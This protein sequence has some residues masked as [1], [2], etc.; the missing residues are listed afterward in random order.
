MRA[1]AALLILPI[2]TSAAPPAAGPVYSGIPPERY[3]GEGASIVIMANNVYDYCP[4]E[5]RP[6]TILLGCHFKTDEGLS[7]IVTPNPCFFDMEADLYAR[8]ACH[9][10]G[11]ANGWEG[12]HPL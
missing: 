7:I 1:L 10:K 12:H 8:I 3:W 11:H 9:E 4:I 5:P 6:N 2:L